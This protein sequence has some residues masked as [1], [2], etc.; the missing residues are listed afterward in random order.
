[1]Q[2]AIQTQLTRTIAFNIVTDSGIPC[3]SV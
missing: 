3:S 2:N 1:M